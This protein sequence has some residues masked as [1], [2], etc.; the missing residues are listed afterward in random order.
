MNI[1]K[2]KPLKFVQI[3]DMAK[4][5]VEKLLQWALATQ[6]WAILKIKD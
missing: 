4:Q 6:I 5:G 2:F 3:L 1:S